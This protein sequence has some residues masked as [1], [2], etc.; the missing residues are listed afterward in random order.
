MSSIDPNER[1]LVAAVCGNDSA[2][3]DRFFLDVCGP[4]TVWLAAKFQYEDLM[5]KLYEHLSA[6]DWRRLRTWEGKSA[7]RTWVTSVAIRLCFADKKKIGTNE[8]ANLF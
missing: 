8:T 3:I 2:A 7:L 6:D 5:G 1:A 4:V